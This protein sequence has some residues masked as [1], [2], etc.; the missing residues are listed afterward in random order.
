[1]VFGTSFYLG[2]G[3]FLITGSFSAFFSYLIDF[4]VL[5]FA[6]FFSG[7]FGLIFYSLSSNSI[8][9]SFL[10]FKIGVTTFAPDYEK[11]YGVDLG[12]Y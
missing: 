1:L 5:T 12:L 9:L 6:S 2:V 11:S 10:G 8:F 3:F 7:F 4:G